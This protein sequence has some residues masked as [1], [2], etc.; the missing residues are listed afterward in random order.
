[1]KRSLGILLA[2]ILMVA[3]LAACSGTTA[4]KPSESTTSSAEASTSSETTATSPAVDTKEPA[5]PETSAAPETTTSTGSPGPETTAS[6]ESPSPEVTTT[7]ESPSPEVTATTESPSPEP[8]ETA[9]ATNPA[10]LAIDAEDATPYNTKDNA[11]PLGKWVYIQNKNYTSGEYEPFYIRVTS[12][13]RDQD[14]IQAALDAYEGNRDFSLS[15]DLARDIEY[16]IIEYE[17]YFSPDYEAREYGI[18]VPST[19]FSATPTETSGFRT[20]GGMSYIGVGGAYD[21]EYNGRNFNPH[22]GDTVQERSIFTVLKNYDESE[23]VLRVNWYDG[24][25]VVENARELY[26]AAS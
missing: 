4:D 8:T 12:V 2:L 23:Y 10:G 18:T 20:P 11:V 14:E 9:G 26:F 25:I 1:M 6:T 15:E 16:G 13:I 19:S 22:P 17:I 24:E 3:P 5:T 21:L 7:T